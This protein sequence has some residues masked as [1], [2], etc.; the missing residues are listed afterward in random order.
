MSDKTV[1]Y[2]IKNCDNV[3]S[4]KTWL[5]E[6][7]IDY[8]F[9]D[10]R[11]DG[12]SKDQLQIWLSRLSAETL[13][14]TRSTTWKQLNSDDQKLALGGNASAVVMTYPTLIKRPILESQGQI[15]VGFDSEE[16]KTLFSL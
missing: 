4:A 14:N 3:K 8:H 12:L 15:L 7:G 1:L 6:N 11:I 9:H 13:I 2:G 16:Y 10:L 5:E